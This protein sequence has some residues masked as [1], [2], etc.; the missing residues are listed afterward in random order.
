M[1]READAGAL[2]LD[3]HLEAVVARRRRRPHRAVP[4]AVRMPDGV[5]AG[6]RDREL[7]VGQQLRADRHALAP[8]P[9][10]ASRARS[11]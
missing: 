4:V 10:S 5:A 7:Q 9:P 1:Q 6:L 8:L 2:V 3:H 11:R